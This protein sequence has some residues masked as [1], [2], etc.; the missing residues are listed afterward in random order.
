MLK[1]LGYR[2]LEI[3]VDSSTRQEQRSPDA[4]LPFGKLKSTTVL[5]GDGGGSWVAPKNMLAKGDFKG[6]TANATACSALS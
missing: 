5:L 2:F 3:S 4:E 1:H 6:I